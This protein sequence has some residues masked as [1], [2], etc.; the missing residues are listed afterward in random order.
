M[1]RLF[2]FSTRTDKYGNRRISLCA[3]IRAAYDNMDERL[4]RIIETGDCPPGISAYARRVY[5]INPALGDR[6]YPINEAFYR[7][8]EYC[9]FRMDILRSAMHENDKNPG[10]LPGVENGH[11][12]G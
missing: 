6:L 10:L 3:S 11:Y 7:A 4:K 9:C 8:L 2:A 5:T 1:C 12:T